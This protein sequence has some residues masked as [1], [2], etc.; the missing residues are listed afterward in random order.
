MSSEGFIHVRRIV[1]D[2]FV[3]RCEA[4][5]FHYTLYTRLRVYLK[6][7]TKTLTQA[8]HRHSR[9]TPPST[10]TAPS[11]ASSPKPRS[12][13]RADQFDR[14]ERSSAT[15]HSTRAPAKM[16][17]KHAS[18][19]V[20]TCQKGSRS[21]PALTQSELKHVCVASNRDDRPSAAAAQH[22]PSRHRVPCALRERGARRASRFLR[23][24]AAIARAG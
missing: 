18:T 3:F 23:R 6:L 20:F 19:A 1:I 24:T 13:S 10:T 12:S 22:V 8:V 21:S 4:H 15:G 5:E 16:P 7:Y 9:T 14:R 2:T 11:R 17:A